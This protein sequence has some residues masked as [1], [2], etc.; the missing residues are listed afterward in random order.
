[1]LLP[2]ASGYRQLLGIFMNENQ[3]FSDEKVIQKSKKSYAHFDLRTNLLKARKYISNPNKIKHHGFYPFIKYVMKYDRFHKV[4]GKLRFDPKE[5]T[6]CYSAH[7]DRCIYQYYGALLNE[8]YNLRLKSDGINNVPVAYRTDLHYNNIDIFRQVMDFI[9][10]YPSCYVMIGD[11]TDFF[12]RIDHQYLKKQLCNLLEVSKLNPDYYAVFKSITQYS[13][14]DLDDILELN[15]LKDTRKNRRKLNSKSRVL[16]VSVF[17]A[18]RNHIER[19]NSGKGIPQGSAISACLANIYMLEID[20]KIS[21]FVKM[22][23]GIYR[24]YSDDFIIILPTKQKTQEYLEC[25]IEFFNKYH[26]KGL[27]EL[28]PDKTQV[29]KLDGQNNLDNIGHLFKPKLNEVNKNINFLGFSFDGNFVRLRGKTIS[30]YNYRRKHK[31]KG[32]A[33]QYTKNKGFKGSD[34]LY[35]MYSKRGIYGKGNFLTYAQ[36]AKKEFPNDPI[37]TPIK[38]NMVKIRR[39]LKK[40][41][42]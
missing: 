14:W 37:D 39:M 8:R 5:R 11:F 27:L 23:G 13:T 10:K 34:K 17:K 38:N 36:R 3:W 35:M 31:A 40:F 6:I 20:K 2:V 1:M 7:I 9:R 30:K 4:D 18:N 15:N 28:Q 42:T 26:D 29:F 22:H 24:R 25:I 33:H 19:N 16:P 21:D 32:I 12:G 41:K